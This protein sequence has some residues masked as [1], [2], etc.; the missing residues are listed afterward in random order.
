MI[1]SAVN[2]IRAR[3]DNLECDEMTWGATRRP[4]LLRGVLKPGEVNWSA[5][6]QTLDAARQPGG[7]RIEYL[8]YC[9]DAG[10]ADELERRK[11]IMAR[12]DN[13]ERR[14]GDLS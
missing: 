1:W 6:N 10:A 3:R 14:K 4:E 7:R 8:C 11:I 5:M 12:R 13:L 9:M 2:Q